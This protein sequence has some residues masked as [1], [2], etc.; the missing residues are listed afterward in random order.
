MRLNHPRVACLAK[1]ASL[2]PCCLAGARCHD[3]SGCLPIAVQLL[4][5]PQGAAGLACTTCCVP[6]DACTGC[7]EPRR[8]AAA[9]CPPQRPRPP[10]P[11]SPV[12][13]CATPAQL[14]RAQS[15]CTSINEI[16]CHGI[17]DRRKL[18]EGDIVN[19]DVSVYYKGYHG[20][21]A[22]GCGCARGCACLNV[23]GV[24]AHTLE[25]PRLRHHLGTM[26]LQGS[27]PTPAQCVSARGSCSRGGR[28]TAL[29]QGC[30]G[31]ACALRLN[32]A[33]ALP[34]RPLQAT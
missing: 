15:V 10:V 30:W 25:G 12:P 24:Q 22:G 18:E 6:R 5:L 27:V 31:R 7:I 14:T 19:V 33:P 8:R 1:R 11:R 21:A 9:S 16:I 17:P 29:E 34:R 13:P 2:L 32:R 4:Q 28:I 3:C 23:S 20:A 26:G